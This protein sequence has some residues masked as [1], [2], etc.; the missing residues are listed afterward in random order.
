MISKNENFHAFRIS[1]TNLM[2]SFQLF[3]DG[4][5]VAAM[6]S[7]LRLRIANEDVAQTYVYLLTHKTTMSFS[8]V[9]GGDKERFYG[10]FKL[11]KFNGM[12]VNKKMFSLNSR[13][14]SCR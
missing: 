4:W 11:V 3:S 5:F 6:D 2:C 10:V 8:D 13:C 1:Q 7:Y 9:F 12:R 14:F